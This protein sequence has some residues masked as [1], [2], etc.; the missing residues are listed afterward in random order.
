MQATRNGLKSI[1][2]T[3]GKTLLVLAVLTA[4]AMLLSVSFCVVASV[5]GYLRDADEYFHTVAELEYMG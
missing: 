3:P 4:L 5:T 1:L 2:R